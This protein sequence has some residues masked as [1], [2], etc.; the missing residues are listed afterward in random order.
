M[1]RK[2]C[3]GFGAQHCMESSAKCFNIRENFLAA[4]KVRGRQDCQP[5]TVGL[6]NVFN[7]IR[8]TEFNIFWSAMRTRTLKPRA[9]RRTKVYLIF[10]GICGKVCVCVCVCVCVSKERNCDVLLTTFGFQ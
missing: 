8:I 6:R 4:I 7:S 5:R 1:W 3:L 10:M 9:F 2:M